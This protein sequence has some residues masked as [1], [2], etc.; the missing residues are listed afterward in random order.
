M[1]D[2]VFII[3]AMAA[4][5]FGLRAVGYLVG[6]RL[7]Q[8]GRVAAAMNALPG[9]ILIG[10]VV[11]QALMTGV[12]ESLAALIA[13]ATAVLTRNVVAAMI[14]GAAS[15]WLLRGVFIP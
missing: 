4:V 5:T 10:I 15:V 9:S 1:N 6:A 3:L 11:P 7:P 12:A 2:A 14:A 13:G 8:R